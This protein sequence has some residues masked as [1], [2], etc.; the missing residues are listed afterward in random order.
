VTEISQRGDTASSNGH[1]RKLVQTL[2]LFRFSSYQLLAVLI[3]L[4]VSSPLVQALSYGRFIEALLLTLVLLSAVLAVGGRRKMLGLAI[5]LVTPALL[6]IWLEHNTRL[7]PAG[8]GMVAAMLP[9]G[10]TI[11][12]LLRFVLKS[13]RITSEVLCIAV[14]NYLLLGLLWSL[15]Y[16]LVEILSPC[17]FRSGATGGDMC[18]IGLTPV[19]FSFVTLCTVGYGDIYPASDT[20]RMLA[21]MEAMTGT[22]YIAVLIARLVAL[23]STERA[24]RPE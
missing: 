2:G 21:L 20:A 14:S 17:S 1:R 22:F 23:Y 15:A 10:F 24:D 12:T 18:M 6:V 13:K 11:V 7:L 8:S 4:L 9:F 19:Y 16:R 3:L 5:L